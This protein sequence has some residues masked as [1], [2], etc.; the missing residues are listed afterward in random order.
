MRR[1]RQ[2]ARFVLKAA[3]LRQLLV[4]HHGSGMGYQN[5]GKGRAAGKGKGKGKGGGGGRKGGDAAAAAHG[6]GGNGGGNT[7]WQCKD[8]ANLW[9]G[10]G[11][12]YCGGCGKPI[13]E[14]KRI[15]TDDKVSRLIRAKDNELKS[16][17]TD[18]K[19]LQ[20][21]V[22]DKD[23]GGKGGGGKGDGG[24]AKAGA[25]AGSLNTTT[26]DPPFGLDKT[27]AIPNKEI[28]IPYMGQS[29]SLAV[30]M[31]LFEAHKP[32]FRTSQK[33]SSTA[34]CSS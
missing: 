5:G 15:P 1:A 28:R 9:N 24:P 31:G 33:T 25:V 2:H 23:K 21:F 22:Y 29:V 14:C 13:A 30:C 4:R 26:P 6:V 20:D 32:H 10:K 7:A 18:F 19:K 12:L 16:L 17:R 3:K 11:S 34:T 27:K 8:C